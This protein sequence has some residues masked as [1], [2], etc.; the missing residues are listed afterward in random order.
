MAAQGTVMAPAAPNDDKPEDETLLRKERNSPGVSSAP[1][2]PTIVNEVLSRGDG[3]PL[4][5]TTRSFMEHRF[6]HD[7]SRVRIH[8]N[9]YASASAHAV[10]AL[11]YTVGRDV[12]FER[13]QYAPETEAGR[14]LLA[15]EL[16]HVVQQREAPVLSASPVQIGEQVKVHEQTDGQQVQREDQPAQQEK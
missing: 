10:N 6:G 7:F 2:I 8:T 16:T 12:V 13:E 5:S 9:E 1:G 15:H 11:A 3:Q 4:D 14:R